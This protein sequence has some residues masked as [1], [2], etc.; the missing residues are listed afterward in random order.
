MQRV[1]DFLKK[2]T[3]FYLATVE[4]D[5]PHVRPFS[6][7]NVFE[8]RIYIQTGKTKNVSRQIHANPN[9]EICGMTGGLW[10][11]I[12]AVAV[13]DSRMEVRRAMLDANP[14]LKS[15]YAVDDENAEVFYLRDATAVISSFSTDPEV[16]RF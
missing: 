12:R 11:R 15:R 3:V 8:G 1:Y 6:A 9:I 13:E 16:I 2:C 4:G 10:I 5:R 14:E 7:V